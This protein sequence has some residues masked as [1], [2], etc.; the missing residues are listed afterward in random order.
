M[1]GRLDELLPPA[2]RDAVAQALL[3]FDRLIPGCAG[4]EGQL[5]GLE[6][7]SSGPVRLPRD[8]VTRRAVGFSNVYPVGEG[9]G[10]AGGI[11]SAALDGAN[12]A[13]MMVEHGVS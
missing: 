10:Y 3:R 11:M 9:A 13:A 7:R 2:V 6:S 1:P 5:L 12:T 4:N 8:P